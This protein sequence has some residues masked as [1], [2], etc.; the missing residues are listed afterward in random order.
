MCSIVLRE[1]KT[2]TKLFK[3]ENINIA[4]KTDNTI[5]RIEMNNFGV[6]AVLLP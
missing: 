2:I 1:I 6:G 4:Y 3:D 5:V